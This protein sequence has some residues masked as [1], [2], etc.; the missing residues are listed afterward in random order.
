[1]ST[2]EIPK[3]EWPDFFLEF[4]RAHEGRP[5]MVEVFDLE[6]GAQMEAHEVTFEEISV[7][8]RAGDNERIM[9][10]L[11]RTPE[12]HLTHIISAPERVRIERAEDGLQEA[13]QIESGDATTLLRFAPRTL[14]QVSTDA[15]LEAKH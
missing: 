3:N 7:E 1:M 8:F 11:G 15:I 10:L 2:R 14:P 9:L 6:I 12:A 13:L 5:V 4:S